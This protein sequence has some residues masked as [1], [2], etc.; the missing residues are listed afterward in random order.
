MVELESQNKDLKLKKM[1]LA[2]N[3]S[4]DGMI[5]DPTL[6]ATHGSGLLPT[7]SL[8]QLAYQQQQW[9]ELQQ[10]AA[11]GSRGTGGTIDLAQLSRYMKGQNFK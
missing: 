6:S 9:R 2:T 8:L 7:R 10:L 3:R 11:I 4:G 1:M 5:A